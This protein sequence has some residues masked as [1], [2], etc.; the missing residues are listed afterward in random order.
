MPDTATLEKPLRGFLPAINP[1]AQQ[2]MDLAR[3][4]GWAARVGRHWAPVLRQRESAISRPAHFSLTCAGA[5]LAVAVDSAQWPELSCLHEIAD[6]RRRDLT[7]RLVLSGLVA[8]LKQLGSPIDGCRVQDASGRALP[9]DARVALRVGSFD[10]DLYPDPLSHALAPSFGAARGVPE[11]LRPAVDAWVLGTRVAIGGRTFQRE[12]LLALEKGDVV[13]GGLDGYAR[14]EIVSDGAARV[15]AAGRL[16]DEGQMIMSEALHEDYPGD[17]GKDMHDDFVDSLDD[18]EDDD[19]MLDEEFQDDDDFPGDDFPGD[20]FM[21]GKAGPGP[22]S[23]QDTLARLPMQVRYE[24]AG[25]QLTVSRACGLAEG[26]VLTLPASASSAVVRLV[27]QGRT[28]ARG[29]LVCIGEQLGVRITSTGA[30][31]D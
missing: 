24:I 2:W 16:N 7:A 12:S 6:P 15:S 25:P 31:H 11:A 20:D 17:A 22:A 14:L 10:V 13:L 19:A 18:D 30:A 3:N 8:T 28:I 9:P 26:D 27:C 4:D 5:E 29:E 1:A 21:A 23:L